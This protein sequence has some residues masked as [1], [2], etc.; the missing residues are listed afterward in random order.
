MLLLLASAANCKAEFLRSTAEGA[1][2]GKACCSLIPCSHTSVACCFGILHH[3]Q[4]S[5]YS[6]N[7]I[8]DR[9]QKLFLPHALH[10]KLLQTLLQPAQ[11]FALTKPSITFSDRCHIELRKWAPVV[12]LPPQKAREMQLAERKH[13]CKVSHTCAAAARFDASAASSHA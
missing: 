9:I 3:A 6:L 10:P 11:D 13:T 7:S 8:S 5:V 4:T 12:Q 2:T 1:I